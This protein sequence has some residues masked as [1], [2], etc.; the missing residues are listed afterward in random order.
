ME[1]QAIRRMLLVFL[2]NGT[3]L[4]NFPQSTEKALVTIIDPQECKAILVGTIILQT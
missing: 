2:V 1:H 3:E 4:I